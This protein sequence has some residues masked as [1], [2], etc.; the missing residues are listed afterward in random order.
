[1]TILGGWGGQAYPPSGLL[2][3]IEIEEN[4][5]VHQIWITTIKIF[6]KHYS[7]L[8]TTG[9]SIKVVLNFSNTYKQIFLLSSQ[10]NY[11]AASRYSLSSP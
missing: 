8:N 2:E 5:E 6:L 10:E 1:M 7:I 11:H 4:K 3:K 9:L